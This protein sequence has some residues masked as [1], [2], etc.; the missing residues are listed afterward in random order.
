MISIRNHRLIGCTPS[1]DLRRIKDAR[2]FLQKRHVAP[3]LMIRPVER[4]EIYDVN[5]SRYG[6]KVATKQKTDAPPLVLLQLDGALKTAPMM[7]EKGTLSPAS[8]SSLQIT[9]PVKKEEGSSTF[10]DS[11]AKRVSK[12]KPEQIEA[13]LAMQNK[14]EGL[15]DIVI[16]KDDD[17]VSLLSQ[18]DD[19]FEDWNEDEDFLL[20]SSVVLDGWRYATKMT[21]VAAAPSSASKPDRWASA[22]IQTC[23]PVALPPLVEYSW[24]LSA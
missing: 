1:H 11:K 23:T 6:P 13:Y 14:P 24:L 2:K 12:L 19:T 18:F 10:N 20:T 9:A 22:G 16:C 21:T 15:P 7:K 4:E 5:P 8:D 17:E 3:K